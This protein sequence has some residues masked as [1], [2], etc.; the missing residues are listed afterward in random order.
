[1]DGRLIPLAEICYTTKPQ[2]EML[3]SCILL[4]HFSHII[5]RKLQTGSMPAK[6][7]HCG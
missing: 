5:T 7:K 6:L 2:T 4:E 1:M 3:S